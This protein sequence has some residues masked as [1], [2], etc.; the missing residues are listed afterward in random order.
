MS[1]AL[2]RLEATKE[3]LTCSWKESTF[4]SAK[5]QEA[6]MYP[7]LFWLIWSPEPWIP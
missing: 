5:P 2:I 4:T 7:E 3:I 6:N 1:M